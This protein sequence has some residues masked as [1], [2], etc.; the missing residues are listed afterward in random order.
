MSKGWRV[1]LSGPVLRDHTSRHRTEVLR[2]GP[3]RLLS[4]T[5]SMARPTR[6]PSRI[7]WTARNT[8]STC[9]P[10]IGRSFGRPLRPTWRRA[11]SSSHR[12]P[13]RMLP[14]R[15]PPGPGDDPP[16]GGCELRGVGGFAALL[17]RLFQLLS[18]VWARA[19]G[20]R[21]PAWAVLA[22]SGSATAGPRPVSRSTRG[23]VT[24][25]V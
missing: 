20:S 22:P 7:A 12:H 9:R 19:P 4:R 14:G 3:A 17:R 1:A 5:T 6:E 11:G 8:R 2:D 15:R 25:G 21:W 18:W 24:A 23:R 13:Q 16:D 10:R